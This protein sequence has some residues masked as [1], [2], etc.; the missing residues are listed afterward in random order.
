MPGPLEGVR[1]IDLTMNVLGPMATQVL[2][3]YG[4][5]VLKIEQPSGDPM[6]KI[7]PCRTADMGSYYLNLNR[8][9]RSVLLD[10]KR[11]P[12]RAALLRLIAGA[13]VF[14]HN[15]RTSAAGRLGLDY[16]ALSALNPRLI[17][18]SGTG[19]RKNSRLRDAP[20]FDD[21]MQ[22]QS[23]I[24]ALNRG[25]DG[26]PRYF[27][28]VIADKFCGHTL[29]S[30]IGMALYNRERTGKGQEVHVPMMETMLAFNLIEHLW[31][32]S[33]GEKEQ[34]LGYPRMMSP[35]RR[36]YPT[37]DGHVCVLAVTDEQWRRLFAAMDQPGLI[38]D[39]R[40][41]TLRDRGHNID[42]LYD[43]LRTAMAT[44]T[45]EEWKVRLTAADLPN[46]SVNTLEDI[47]DDEYLA[48]TEFFT[49]HQHPVEG[50]LVMMAVPVEFSGSPTALRALP[51]KLGA[52][53]DAVL[54]E[55]GLT[56]AEIDAAT[57]GTSRA[58]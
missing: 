38:N 53:T 23:G 34:G 56:V 3:D 27:P 54:R 35:H 31:G 16:P 1:V 32:A 6:R 21:V 4:A 7:G 30:A 42:A 44:R 45:T 20:A 17:Y 14:V 29:A 10:L 52:D 13:D 50:K 47:V 9:K 39:P 37:K 5:E 12:A 25:D 15:I 36:P 48:E 49:E 46:G 40:F 24:A 43:A 33:I 28:T 55:A 58:A 57:E 18:G 2:G 41:A 51:P 26:A 11:E 22:G 19:Y 8:N